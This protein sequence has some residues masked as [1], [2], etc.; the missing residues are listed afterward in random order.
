MSVPSS[1]LALTRHRARGGVGARGRVTRRGGRTLT[2]ATGAAR[3]ELGEVDSR[4]SFDKLTAE[5]AITVVDFQ[6]TWCRKC[7]MIKA[8]LQKLAA[9]HEKVRIVT[10]DVNKVSQELIR[11]CGV[12]KMPTLQIYKSGEKLWELVAGEDGDTVST[13]LH[14][15][16]ERLQAEEDKGKKKNMFGGSR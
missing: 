11:A 12:T 5:D 16:L 8:R 7:M 9:T 4:E 3:K 15:E 10:V 6:A 13:K 2:R 1:R 14:Y